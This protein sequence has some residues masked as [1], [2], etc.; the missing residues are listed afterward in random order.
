MMRP[1]HCE[2]VVPTPAVRVI[3]EIVSWNQCGR[4]LRGRAAAGR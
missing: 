1:V 3:A 4:R 2:S